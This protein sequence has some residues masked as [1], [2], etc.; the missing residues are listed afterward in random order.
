MR[1]AL[2]E[3]SYRVQN[4]NTTFLLLDSNNYHG[5]QVIK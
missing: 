2:F 1:P 3:L 5:M 4:I